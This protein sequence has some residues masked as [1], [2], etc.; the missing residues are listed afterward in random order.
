MRYLLILLFFFSFFAF[1]DVTIPSG[2]TDTY[3]NWNYN[4]TGIYLLRDL[5]LADDSANTM[6]LV[7]PDL[8]DDATVFQFPADNGVNLQYLMTDGNDVTSWEELIANPD[9]DNVTIEGTAG[10][11]FIEMADQSTEPTSPSGTNDLRIF[12]E[13]KKIKYKDSSGTVKEVGSGSGGS[14]GINLLAEYNYNFENGD[15]GSWT[16]GWLPPEAHMA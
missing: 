10:D 4:R 9:F 3:T 8:A 7:A 2:T 5:Y 16:R 11:G 12:A 1:G 6:K 15:D 14:S 13:G